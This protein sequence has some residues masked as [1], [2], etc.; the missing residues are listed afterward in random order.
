MARRDRKDLPFQG[1][2]GNGD[3]I[4][5]IEVVGL[6]ED[7]PAG[8][9]DESGGGEVVLSLDDELAGVDSHDPPSSPPNGSAADRLMR[10]QADFDN[11]K[12]RMEREREHFESQA[13]AELV[14]RILPVLDNF[15]RAL[16]VGPDSGDGEALRDGVVLI[17]RQLLDELRKEGLEAIESLGQP[18]DPQLHEAVEND[19]DPGREDYT[20]V[21]EVR[22]G[23]KLRERLLRPSLV[24]V[25]VDGSND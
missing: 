7:S 9:G 6:D 17:F 23:Y 10:L 16:S 18:F 1:V 4:E 8:S 19:S 24:K 11:L 5:I 15:E 21:E 20:V 25:S 14:N 22:R 13:S 12:K 2:A 3:D